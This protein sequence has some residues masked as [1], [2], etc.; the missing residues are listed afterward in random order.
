M[1]KR[2]DF[3]RNARDFYRTPV[4][5]VLPLTPFLRTTPRFAEPFV[6]DGAIV[7]ALEP[8]GYECTFACDIQPEG[9]AKAYAHTMGVLETNSR[10]YARCD[11]IVT[12]PPWPRPRAD[13]EPTVSYI[14][15]LSIFKPTWMLLT[16]D[17]MHN[18]YAADLIRN[19]CS[20]IVSVGRVKWMAGTKNTGMENAAWY[21]FWGDEGVEAPRFWPLRR[22]LPRVCAIGSVEDLI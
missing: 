19:H 13:G 17:F 11:V 21:C 15:A 20:D 10:D 7:R 3:K 1:G 22:P 2:S 8:L 18:A 6:G 4:E 9:E 5:A 16:A 14:R 12:N